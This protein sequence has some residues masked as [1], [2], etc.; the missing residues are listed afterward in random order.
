V[1]R[2]SGYQE[3]RIEAVPTFIIGRQKLTGVQNKE[4]LEGVIGEAMEP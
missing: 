4:T 1:H 2:P 3:A